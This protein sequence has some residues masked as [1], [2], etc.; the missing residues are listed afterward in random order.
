M[1]IVPID[2]PDGNIKLLK[3]NARNEELIETIVSVCKNEDVIKQTSVFAQ[4]LFEVSP[5]PYHI[6]KMV[7][8]FCEKN[9]DLE[10]KIDSPSR[11]LIKSPQAT[12]DS[13]KKELG[14]TGQG[15]DV[16][17]FALLISTILS[18]LKIKHV[19]R[20]IS[21]T[22][23]PGYHHVYVVAYDKEKEI[24]MDLATKQFE[25]ECKYKRKL[26]YPVNV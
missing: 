10:V 4:G 5:N 17:S 20:F 21:E 24:V 8:R 18:N 1:E 25:K 23:N 7:Y 11:I 3:A 9:I 19:L 15:T 2:K 6:C 16:S 12:Y 14:G 22:D 26:D 13:R